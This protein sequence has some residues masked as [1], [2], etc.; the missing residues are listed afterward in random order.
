MISDPA[1]RTPLAAITVTNGLVPAAARVHG[2]TAS[3][4]ASVAR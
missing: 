2:I 4:S 1:P 3:M